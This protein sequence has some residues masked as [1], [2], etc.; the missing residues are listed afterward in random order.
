MVTTATLDRLAELEQR[1]QALGL[2]EYRDAVDEA[3]RAL[4]HVEIPPADSGLRVERLPA[5][6]QRRMLTLGRKANR[7]VLTAAERSEYEAFI[8]EVERRS[9]R[10]A[11]DALATHAERSPERAATLARD[12]A[13]HLGV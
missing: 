3:L 5:P 8:R 7:G 6:Q 2:D 12:A 4:G 11:L 10:A 1:L 13:A 9:A